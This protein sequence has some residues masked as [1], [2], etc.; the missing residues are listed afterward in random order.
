MTSDLWPMIWRNEAWIC[1]CASSSACSCRAMRAVFSSLGQGGCF[2]PNVKTNFLECCNTE[3]FIRADP[4]DSNLATNGPGKKKKLAN[5]AKE[6]WLKDHVSKWLVLKPF[7][8]QLLICL[9]FIYGKWP[10]LDRL[11]LATH[12]P[13]NL[14]KF[15]MIYK[16]TKFYSYTP[17]ISPI[18]AGKSSDHS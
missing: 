12:H 11:L 6:T 1:A 9:S 5:V 13:N 17:T 3:T 18:F 4:T 14:I 7:P 15:G 10:F 8:V 16:V 2:F